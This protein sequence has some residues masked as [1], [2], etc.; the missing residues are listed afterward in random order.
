[1]NQQQTHATFHENGRIINTEEKLQRVEL[2]AMK[3]D[4]QTLKLSQVTPIICLTRLHNCCDSLTSFYFPFPPFFTW[5]I[6]SC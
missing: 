5:N 6:Y 3:N 4:S 1:M 2:R